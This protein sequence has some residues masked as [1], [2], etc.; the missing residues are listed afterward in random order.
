[1]LY[2]LM[3]NTAGLVQTNLTMIRDSYPV[4]VI[5]DK[6][7]DMVGW[8][9]GG[10]DAVDEE[11]NFDDTPTP[12]PSDYI[13]MYDMVT[14][15]INGEKMPI[16]RWIWFGI[17]AVI[18]SIAIFM[19][20]NHMIMLPWAIRLF[21]AIY[22]ANIA[23][24][25]DFTGLNLIYFTLMGYG[26]LFM[27]RYYLQTTDPKINIIPFHTFGFLPLRTA[28]NNWTDVPNT[29][30]RYL[31][32]GADGPDYNA[33]VRA[34]ED[35]V[36]AQKAAFP[37]YSALEGTFKLKPLFEAF[38]NHV[39]N[40]NLPGFMPPPPDTSAQNAQKVVE[41][42]QGV[43]SLSKASDTINVAKGV[44]TIS[45]AQNVQG[46]TIASNVVQKAKTALN[47]SQS[48]QSAPK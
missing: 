47:K 14:R 26:A 18:T 16:T 1:M 40:M 3:T 29:L 33:L 42:A 45:K 6:F 39:I 5:T 8:K 37:N 19:V 10:T 9:T 23:A 13:T 28:K 27:Y 31:H 46:I 12:K 34:T 7:R 41:M 17:G 22:I 11:D 44:Q 24:F 32:I 4:T 2:Q 36:E 21:A 43:Q 20:T 38:E 35:Y 25:A 15:T 30:W 48:S